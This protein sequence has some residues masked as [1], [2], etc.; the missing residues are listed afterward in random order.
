V[1]EQTVHDRD[2]L[3]ADCLDLEEVSVCPPFHLSSF[4]DSCHCWVTSVV[5]QQQ[6]LNKVTGFLG[7]LLGQVL[8]G[9]FR[10]RVYTQL[11]VLVV[12]IEP[13]L[14]HHLHD[15]LLDISHVAQIPRSWLPAPLLPSFLWLPSLCSLC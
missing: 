6:G 9:L 15:K 14:S 7:I 2:E 10:P 8:E 5:V 12:Q 4:E 13:A 11:P 1:P 3:A